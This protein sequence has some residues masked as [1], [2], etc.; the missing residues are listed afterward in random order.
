MLKRFQV[1]VIAVLCIC[2]LAGCAETAD[3]TIPVGVVA[4]RTDFFSNGYA[5][6]GVV[7]PKTQV[8]VVTK[9]SGTVERTYK[10]VGDP[11]SA[12]EILLQMDTRTVRDQLRS[13][14]AALEQT[15]VTVSQTKLQ[16]ETALENARIA[17]DSAQ[18]T[19]QQAQHDYDNSEFLFEAGAISEHALDTAQATLDK[20]VAAADTTNTTLETAQKNLDIYIREE[21][22]DGY[23]TT[24]SGSE[25]A[26]NI[27]QT[28]IDILQGQM[29]DYT[30]TSPI[31]GVIIKKNVVAGGTTGQT[32]V[33][34]VADIDQV[35]I[36][37][38]VPQ[39]EITK[40]S[41]GSLAQVFFADNFSI[42]TPVTAIANSA[43]AANLY[44]VQV[45]VDNKDHYF[46]PG[47]NAKVVFVES[48]D[49]SI[50]VPYNSV[51]SSSKDNYIFVIENNR[52]KKVFVNVLGKNSDEISIEPIGLDLNEN[53]EVAAH[54]A[55]L[56]KDGD[57]VKR[58]D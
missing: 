57:A 33:Y 55:N 42:E 26:V 3:K 37:T 30:V 9:H 16:H 22:A 20:A 48:R 45:V 32:P 18:V 43:N 25:A 29:A 13:A 44:M 17:Y 51:I 15:T 46:K 39:E 19:L 58:E 5:T 24:L 12:G 28:Q 47:M 56:L 41:L 54:N 53:V 1:A 35:I 52:A 11:V 7:E 31:S 40:L 10:E 36:S 27:P 34:S 6:A 23:D 4:V 50:I 38:A 21:S 14:R 2:L 8:D 49:K